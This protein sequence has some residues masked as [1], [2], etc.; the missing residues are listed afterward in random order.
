MINKGG[1]K[2]AQSIKQVLRVRER[3]DLVE[4]GKYLTLNLTGYD[5]EKRDG[6]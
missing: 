4:S 2:K 5:I 1:L 3:E 6:D